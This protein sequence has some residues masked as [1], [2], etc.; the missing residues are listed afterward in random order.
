PDALPIYN[1][2]APKVSATPTETSAMVGTTRPSESLRNGFLP[3]SARLASSTPRMAGSSESSIG[4]QKTRDQ[5]RIMTNSVNSDVM[6][7]AA[8]STQAKP[9]PDATPP[10][11][12][13]TLPMKPENGGIPPMFSAGI[14]YSTA[15]SGEI[16]AME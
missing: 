4:R 2:P 14:I 16:F 6:T 13:P 8:T 5:M 10:L 1:G 12:K 15:M 9:V 11:I 7:E 3:C